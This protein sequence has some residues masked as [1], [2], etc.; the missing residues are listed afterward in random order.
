MHLKEFLF[1]KQMTQQEMAKKL[2]V[3]SQTLWR[4]LNGED[5]RLS[6]AIKI[7]QCTGGLVQCRDL[8]TKCNPDE[9]CHDQK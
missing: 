3:S 5:T 7:E 2:Q 1:R 6:I 8:M 9:Q 4:I